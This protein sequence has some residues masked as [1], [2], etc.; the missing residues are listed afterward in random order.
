MLQSIEPQGNRLAAIGQT[1]GFVFGASIAIVTFDDIGFHDNQCECLLAQARLL[2]DVGLL[3]LMSVRASDNRFKEIVRGVAFSAITFGRLN[4]TT[5]N[6]AT[7][8]LL[9]AG[10]AATRVNTPNTI[11]VQTAECK[12]FNELF[13]NSFQ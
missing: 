1:G 3:A 5:D 12:R 10:P 8:C 9:I 7:H 2:T 13:Q 4:M 11:L 6:Q